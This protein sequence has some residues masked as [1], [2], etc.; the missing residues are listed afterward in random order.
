MPMDN[1]KVV[2]QKLRRSFCESWF[3]ELAL[4]VLLAGTLWG[5]AA[6]GAVAVSQ[7]QASQGQA[8]QGQASQDQASQ[9]QTPAG[10]GARAAQETIVSPKEAK[11]LFRSVDEI[12]QF[13]SD[14]T[15][16]PIKHKVKRRLTKRDEVESYLKKSM[17]DDKDAKRLERS[18]A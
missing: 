10:E 15:G 6:G 8:S 13:A 1:V 18:S 3:W 7:G 16:L 2:A 9:D 12:L 14:D 4:L 17:K 11:E 5:Q